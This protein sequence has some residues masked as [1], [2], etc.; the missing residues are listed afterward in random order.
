MLRVITKILGTRRARRPEKIRA[1]F[2]VSV[3]RTAKETEAV[4]RDTKMTAPQ[5][6]WRV[7]AI[8]RGMI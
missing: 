2:V 3:S 4:T 5:S 8:S 1:H 6:P 7:T